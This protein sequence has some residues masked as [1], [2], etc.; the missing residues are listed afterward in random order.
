MTSNLGTDFVRKGGA[1][2]FVQ[3]NDAEA[4]ADHQKIE[5]AVRDTFRCCRARRTRRGRTP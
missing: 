2:G 4:V 3:T 1:L 5:K